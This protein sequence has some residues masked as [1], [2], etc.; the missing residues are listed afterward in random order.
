MEGQWERQWEGHRER[1]ERRER[2]WERH[3]EGQPANGSDSGATV[4]GQWRDSGRDSG[5]T[6]ENP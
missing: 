1:R 6:K 2:Q 5:A 3:L 4:E